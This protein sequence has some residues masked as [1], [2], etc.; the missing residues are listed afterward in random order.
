MCMPSTC[1]TCS[2]PTYMGCG[3]HIDSAFS[4][5]VEERCPCKARTQAE[6]DEQQKKKAEAAAAA[7][8][9]PQ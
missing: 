7:A 2:K 3:K 5:P 8:V 9:A 4:V 6:F 1:Q